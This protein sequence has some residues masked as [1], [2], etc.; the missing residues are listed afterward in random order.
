MA[1]R[2]EYWCLTGLIKVSFVSAFLSFY[3][4]LLVNLKFF[5]CWQNSLLFN[6]L[7]GFQFKDI[8]SLIHVVVCVAEV[9]NNPDYLAHGHRLPRRRHHLRRARLVKQ[10]L[11]YWVA[12]PFPVFR[13]AGSGAGLEFDTKSLELNILPTFLVQ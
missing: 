8:F 13:R 3:Y 2:I 4:A 1:D 9:E 7:V 11:G 5:F 12:A 10:V 6:C